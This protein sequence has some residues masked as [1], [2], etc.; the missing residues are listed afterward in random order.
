VPFTLPYDNYVFLC[1]Q[2]HIDENVSINCDVACATRD[3]I[4]AADLWGLGH[5]VF[6]AAAAL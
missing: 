5:I 1:K 4:N 3:Y 2:H 6:T